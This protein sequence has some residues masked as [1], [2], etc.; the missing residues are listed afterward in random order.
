M[1][2]ADQIA[3]TWQTFK[4]H[5]LARITAED[6]KPTYTWRELHNEKEDKP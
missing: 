6:Q 2:L 4:A 5:R 1:G 3:E